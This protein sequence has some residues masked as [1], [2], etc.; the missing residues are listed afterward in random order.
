[1]ITPAAT[2]PHPH[3]PYPLEEGFRFDR[4]GA[5]VP[6][7]FVSPYIE[8]GTVFRAEGLAP[9]EHCSVIKTLSARFGLP[10][11][12]ARDRAAPD[13][14]GVLTRDTPRTDAPRFT[15]RDCT[16]LSKEQARDAPLVG[17]QRMIL[18]MA[19]H[20]KGVISLDLERIGAA[21]DLIF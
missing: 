10:P 7:V 20:R 5:R 15:P 8:A 18:D 4:L 14:S 21:L 6:A 16:P 1:M 11:L 19:A 3:P 9:L 12:N 13:L 2:P 17:L